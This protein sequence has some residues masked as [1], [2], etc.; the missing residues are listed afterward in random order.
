M[1]KQQLITYIKTEYGIEPDKPFPKDFESQ[2]FRHQDNRKWFALIMT[3]PANR[4]GLA[5][6]ELVD[7]VNL[8]CDPE[9]IGSICDRKIVFPAYH[10]NKWHWISVLLKGKR[11]NEQVESLVDFSYD[12]T[13]K[14]MRRSRKKEPN[15]GMK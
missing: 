2:V 5:S 10:M 13:K 9:M 3:I 6:E 11:K 14:V 8:K 7:I 1:D 4:L 12:L 15:A